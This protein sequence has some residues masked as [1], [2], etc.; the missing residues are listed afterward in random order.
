[1]RQLLSAFDQDSPIFPLQKKKEKKRK[2][3]CNYS[4]RGN[5]GRKRKKN[6]TNKSSRKEHFGLTETFCYLI[7]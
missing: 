4:W 1:M 5:E 6:P 2:I 3:K 7:V